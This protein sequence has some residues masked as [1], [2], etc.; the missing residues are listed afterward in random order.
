M[1]VKMKIHFE[2]MYSCM[3]IYEYTS[4]ILYWHY[5]LLG[6][7]HWG[8]CR[9]HHTGMIPFQN[10]LTAVILMFSYSDRRNKFSLKNLQSCTILNFLV[11]DMVIVV[12]IF[13]KSLS[14]SQWSTVMV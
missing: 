10:A 3:Y 12:V 9:K 1:K 14:I 13:S 6:Q 4:D 7:A 11:M 5:L 2:N 8:L